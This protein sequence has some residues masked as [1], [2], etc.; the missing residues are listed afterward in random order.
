MFKV[1]ELKKPKKEISIVLSPKKGEVSCVA[2]DIELSRNNINDVD[3]LVIICKNGSF[4]G[5]QY[6]AKI[7]PAYKDTDN[8]FKITIGNMTTRDKKKKVLGSV[9]IPIS[10]DMEFEVRDQGRVYLIL[11]PGL[12]ELYIDGLSA[13]I[14]YDFRGGFTTTHVA[15]FTNGVIY[16][17][18]VNTRLAKLNELFVKARS[19]FN[20]KLSRLLPNNKITWKTEIWKADSTFL[21]TES[22]IERVDLG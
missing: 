7:K 2:G 13:D 8:L 16:E 4:D 21:F 10:D 12:V 5:V 20:E 18:G 6:G 9:T 14:P 17:K 3:W 19:L 15:D 22:C 1:E 11:I